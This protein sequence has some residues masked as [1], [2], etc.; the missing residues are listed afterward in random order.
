MQQN[1][2]KEA[3]RAAAERR[4]LQQTQAELQTLKNELI[5]Q[6]ELANSHKTREGSSLLSSFP[7]QGQRHLPEGLTNKELK[8]LLEEVLG[9][10]CDLQRESEMLRREISQLKEGNKEPTIEKLSIEQRRLQQEINKKEAAIGRWEAFAAALMSI[11]NTQEEAAAAAAANA[12]ANCVQRVR[13]ELNNVLS[14][15]I[16]LY[17]PLAGDTKQQQQQQQQ[18]QQKQQQQQ[19]NRAQGQQQPMGVSRSPS[20]GNSS[21]SNSSSSSSSAAPTERQCTD[22]SEAAAPSAAASPRARASLISSSSSSSSNSSS[23]SSSSSSDRSSGGS[24]SSNR[25]NSSNS[26]SNSSRSG[27]HAE[28]TGDTPSLS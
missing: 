11:I 7:R 10:Y 20:L 5:R 24:D 9:N 14:R 4:Q 6:K 26:S 8:E 15:S 13:E 23:N 18:Q 2:D 17:E 22:N 16:L 1:L 3:G 27:L 28:E 21:N 19:L 12:A 25:S